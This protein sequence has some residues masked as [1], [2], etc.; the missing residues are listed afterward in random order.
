M[1]HPLLRQATARELRSGGQPVHLEKVGHT[2]E[3]LWDPKQESDGETTLQEI[4][5]ETTC[6]LLLKLKGDI[7]RGSSKDVLKR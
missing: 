4:D 6:D 3:G 5:P 2:G 7:G 1:L